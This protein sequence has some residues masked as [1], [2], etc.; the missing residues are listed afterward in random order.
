MHIV[1]YLFNFI[2][3]WNLNL[4]MASKELLWPQKIC[5]AMEILS[6]FYE[7]IK[8]IEFSHDELHNFKTHEY[9]NY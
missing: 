3:Q 6:T 9:H 8:L 5:E 7:F 2:F 1:I 4:N